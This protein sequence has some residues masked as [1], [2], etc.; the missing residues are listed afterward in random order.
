[1]EDDGEGNEGHESLERLQKSI[2]LI[3]TLYIVPGPQEGLWQWGKSQETEHS[4]WFIISMPR[5][6]NK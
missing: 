2:I 6:G 1:M 4:S 3:V 5:I